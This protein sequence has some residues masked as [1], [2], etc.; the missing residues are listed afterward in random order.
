MLDNEE[1]G[2]GAIRENEFTNTNGPSKCPPIM[3]KGKTLVFRQSTNIK[4]N[5]FIFKASTKPTIF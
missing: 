2:G 3:E 5:C 4:R 1:G